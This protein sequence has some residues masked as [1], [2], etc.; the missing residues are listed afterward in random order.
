M[1]MKSSQEG[2]LTRLMLTALTLA[3]NVENLGS[4]QTGAPEIVTW[5]LEENET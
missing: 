2:P 4:G 5:D 1:L 3:D